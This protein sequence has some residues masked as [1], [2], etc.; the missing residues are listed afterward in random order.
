MTYDIGKSIAFCVT[1]PKLREVYAA[2][3]RDRIVHHLIMRK[4]LDLFEDRMIESSYNCRKEKGTI[5]GV[6]DI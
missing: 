2:S 6:R 3:F 4:F 1:Y 5:F